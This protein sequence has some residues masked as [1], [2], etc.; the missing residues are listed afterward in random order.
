MKKVLILL[1]SLFTVL[2]ALAQDKT[3]PIFTYGDQ[4]VYSDE[5]MRVFNKN[6]RDESK[7]TQE[8]IEEY[9]DLYIKFKLKVSE[10]Y[11]RQMDTVPAF[12]KELAGYRKQL[13]Q[14]Y[15][16]DKEVNAQLVQE[17]YERSTMEVNAGHLLILCA[18]DAS[19]EDTL[20][21]YNRVM[22]L[23]NRIVKGGQ[24]FRDLAFQLSEDPSAKNNKGDLGYFTAFQ[25]IYPFENAAFNTPI[26][27]VSM[28]IRTRFGY[29]LVKVYDR[30]ASEG[31][32]E[33]N[34]IMIKY[35]NENDVD[36]AKR[37]IDAVY[38]KLLGGEDWASM[39]EEFSED[40]STANKEGALNWFSRTSPNVP[41]EFKEAAYGLKNVGDISEPVKSK[42]GW[43]IIR[44]KDTR[45]VLSFD[46]MKLSLERKVERDSR[47]E[48]NR[49]VVLERVKKEN[50]F[51]NHIADNSYLM[52]GFDSSLLVGKWV[53]PEVSSD[54]DL[55]SIG[56]RVYKYSEFADY[57][58]AKQVST[59]KSLE[60]TV[61][62]MYQDFIDDENLKYEEA[63]LEDKYEDFKHIMQ[64][65]KDGIL[66]FE[67]T[68]KEVWSKA[69][70]DTIG[71][72]EFYQE[73]ANNYTWDE[74]AD[75]VFLSFKDEK[76]AKKGLKLLK[77][78][79]VSEAK[80]ILNET[81]AL[82]MSTDSRLVEKKDFNLEG[83][84]WAEGTY[85]VTDENNR[86]K[87]V[88]LVRILPEEIKPLKKNLGQV[89][90]DYQQE[91]ESRWLEELRLKFPIEVSA[92]NVKKLYQ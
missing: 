38:S 86:I 18:L 54:R 78:M 55:F 72:N 75:L 84:E 30:R 61:N 3:F 58:L 12:I 91:L 19:P 74:R 20:D 80:A 45:P 76:T 13:A 57:V 79:S 89:T 83:V 69:I 65:Y 81:D 31:E 22:G 56:N 90:S 6:K 21:A 5:F 42:Y 77:K 1:L 82:A 37:R 16:T 43:H 50:N 10:A 44:K 66:L 47:S 46:E 35:Y 17:A 26:G 28:P 32:I 85:K 7:P 4:T 49:A 8:D 73:N 40:F 60:F 67:L 23:R 88:Q 29:H 71:L 41:P 52:A 48:L 62:K 39:V 87:Y 64:E 34:H 68:D 27:E 14:P 70:D 33:V 59:N 92:E 51:K 53:K 2:G 25:M 63:H 11:S 15:M 36:S 24:E 9:L